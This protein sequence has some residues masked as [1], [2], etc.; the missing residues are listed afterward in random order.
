MDTW[1][2]IRRKARQLNIRALEAT[3]G[4]RCAKALVDAALQILDLETAHYEPG[5]RFGKEVFGSLERAA[6]VVNIAS[7]QDLEEELVVIAHEIGHYELH[8]DPSH[9]VT[10]SHSG[11]GGDPV[12]GAAGKVEGYSPRQRQEVQADIFAGEFLCPSDWAREQYVFLGRH[13]VQIAKELKLP[14]RL[15]LSQVIR[16]VLLPPLREPTEQEPGV[17][18]EL[19]HSQ[20]TAATW[21]AGALLVDAG[22]G[23]GKTRTLVHRIKHCLASGIAPANILALTFSNKA[24]EEMHERLSAMDPK[25]SLEMWVGT[26]HSFGLELIT[27]W[28]SAIGRSP[29]VK[30]VDEAGA[31]ALLEANLQKLS[32]YHFQNL[33]EPWA[34]HR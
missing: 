16:A 21:S 8:T 4:D 31:L 28:P 11:L 12:E 19:D 25:A 9:E 7:G 29:H 18:I 26:F 6:Q 13:P 10:I 5:T 14:S 32:L 2:E 30:I 3:Q 27:R 22:P 33:Y 23:T 1:T 24:A 15:V 34:G 17:E 20:K